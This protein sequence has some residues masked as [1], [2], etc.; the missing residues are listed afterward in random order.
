MLADLIKCEIFLV[1][2][3]SQE[4]ISDLI[5]REEIAYLANTRFAKGEISF[6]DYIDCLEVAEVCIDDY[7]VTIENNLTIMGV[8]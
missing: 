1:P 8:L 3:A 5:K 6:Q 7:L 2:Q 4:E